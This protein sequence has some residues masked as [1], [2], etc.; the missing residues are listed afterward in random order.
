MINSSPVY[1]LS[2]EQSRALVGLASAPHAHT[3]EDDHSGVTEGE[4]GFASSCVPA[5]MIEVISPPGFENFFR[6]VAEL[7]AAGRP[8]W[9]LVAP[10]AEHLLAPFAGAS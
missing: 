10:I 6:E 9:E 8:T 3:R 2:N 7:V 1:P 5:L 4:I